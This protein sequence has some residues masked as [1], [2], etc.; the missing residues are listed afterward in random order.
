[1]SRKIK[2]AYGCDNE[3]FEDLA[4]IK[5]GVESELMKASMN[6]DMKIF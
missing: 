2:E 1:M 5:C 6:S 3:A 4:D